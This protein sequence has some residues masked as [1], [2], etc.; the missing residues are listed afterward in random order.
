[1]QGIDEELYLKYANITREDVL[2]N[3]RKDA[4]SRIKYRYLLEEIAKT[5]KINVTDKQAEAE[6]KDMA[7]K[8]NMETDDIIKEFGGLEVMK[9]DLKLRRAIDILKDNN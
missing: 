9:Q 7:L 1:M 2:K 4:E 8:Y 5:E 3:M 6:A